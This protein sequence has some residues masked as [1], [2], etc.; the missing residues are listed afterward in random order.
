MA[1]Q[2]GGFLAQEFLL[3]A[4]RAFLLD[5]VL[6]LA[7]DEGFALSEA[8]FCLV[9]VGATLDKRRFRLAAE[10]QGVFTGF[11]AG[12]AGN[13]I[14]FAAGAFEEGLLFDAAGRAESPGRT[15]ACRTPPCRLQGRGRKAP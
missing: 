2:G 9:V 11:G 5:H 8:P 1:V 3:F 14:G 7:V 13:G 15:P 6:K 4:K 12:F 10:V